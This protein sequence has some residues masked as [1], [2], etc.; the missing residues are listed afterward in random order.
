[1]QHWPKV[2]KNYF[3]GGTF[4]GKVEERKYSKIEKI[5]SRPRLDIYKAIMQF[6]LSNFKIDKELLNNCSCNS[7]SKM[8]LDSK[9]K[10]GEDID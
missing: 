5:F 6:L 2:K 8:L 7:L 1:M 3:R 10:L 9:L 4:G